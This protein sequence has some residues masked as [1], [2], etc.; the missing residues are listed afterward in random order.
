[1]LCIKCNFRYHGIIVAHVVTVWK[2]PGTNRLWG[3]F[4]IDTNQYCIKMRGNMKE[5]IPATMLI[6]DV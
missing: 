4:A 1:M 3:S 2:K 5:R 6:V